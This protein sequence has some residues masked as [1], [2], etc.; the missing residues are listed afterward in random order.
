M[1]I[2]AGIEAGLELFASI[3]SI[4]ES[5]SKEAPIVAAA[6]PII[7]KG[8]QEAQGLSI[9]GASK[10]QHVVNLVT[11]A[12]TV[13]ALVSKGGQQHTFE[14]A[15]AAAPVIAQAVSQVYEAFKAAGPDNAG[16]STQATQ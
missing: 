3:F 12:A 16:I 14:E 15:Q 6:T 11:D 10:T 13:G 9:P 8:I 5:K 1:G 4:F 7:I 2:L